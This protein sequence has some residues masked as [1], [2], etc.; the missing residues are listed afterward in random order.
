[1]DGNGDYAAPNSSFRVRGENIVFCCHY[2]MARKPAIHAG[3][4]GR[5]GVGCGVIVELRISP[6]TGVRKSL[7]IPDH[8]IN[9]CKVSGTVVGAG[10]S[11]LF[12]AF[13]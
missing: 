5:E 13:Q 4:F 6:C 10:A 8:E 3:A 12:F 1:V 9:V 11:S 7:V 2:R